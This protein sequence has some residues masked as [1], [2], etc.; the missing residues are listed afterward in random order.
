MVNMCD[1]IILS[2]KD[3]KLTYLRY[4]DI[5]SSQ[6]RVRKRTGGE[7]VREGGREWERE[8]ERE[9]ERKRGR[10]RRKEGYG[11]SCS[12]NAFISLPIASCPEKVRADSSTR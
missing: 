4:N 5:Q 10:E 2:P 1:I 3:C 6:I 9:G 8:T 11:F 12:A 7:R